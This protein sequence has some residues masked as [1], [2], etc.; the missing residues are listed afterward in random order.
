MFVVTEFINAMNALR[1]S[2]LLLSL[3]DNKNPV[4]VVAANSIMHPRNLSTKHISYVCKL[5]NFTGL[6]FAVK[7]YYR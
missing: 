2:R 3:W 4:D 1:K 7:E 5:D 6:V